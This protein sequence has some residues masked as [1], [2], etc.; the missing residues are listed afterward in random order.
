MARAIEL[1]RRALEEPGTRP[2]GAVVVRD[3]TVVG[4]GL[5]RSR[6]ALDPTSHGETEAIRDACRRL[7]CLDLSGC[8]LYASCEPCPLCVAAMELVGIGR[9]YYGAAAATSREL[10]AGAD[11]RGYRAVDPAELRRKAG[12]GVSDRGMP[13]EQR[14]SDEAAAALRDW[15]RRNPA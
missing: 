9:L 3:G 1:S 2:Y 14:M 5:N 15:A 8:E 12:S 13:V 4:E 11:A 10:M 7:E 6:A